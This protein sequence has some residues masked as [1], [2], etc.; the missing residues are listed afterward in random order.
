MNLVAADVS[1][2]TCLLSRQRISADSRRRLRVLP[3]PRI[4]FRQ[5]PAFLIAHHAA[6]HQDRADAVLAD[7]AYFGTRI[8]PAYGL[9]ELPGGLAA[10]R[11]R[12][13]GG[14]PGGLP[15]H[16]LALRRRGGFLRRGRRRAW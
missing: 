16:D 12:E 15:R 5:L 6:A 1:R 14:V 11:R 7:A 2:R 4:A 9:V 8:E 3:A 10:R 13:R